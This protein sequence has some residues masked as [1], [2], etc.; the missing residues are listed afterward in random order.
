MNPQDPSSPHNVPEQPPDAPGARGYLAAWL[1][2]YPAQTVTAVR[3]RLH[4][5]RR[6]SAD[7]ELDAE[8]AALEALL[9]QAA[10]Q[11]RR[12]IRGDHPEA[13]PQRPLPDAMRAVVADVQRLYRIE[14]D[15]PQ[16]VDAQ[17][18]G[19]QADLILCCLREGLIN[20]AKH[21]GAT[22]CTSSLRIDEQGIGFELTQIGDGA[23]A[24]GHDDAATS[25]VE[26][27]GG[28][29]LRT[30]SDRA[31]ALGGRLKL[32]PAQAPGEQTRLVLELPRG[33]ARAD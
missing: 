5:L 21:A 12:A 26:R 1:H 30:L 19:E 25:A 22:H 27:L 17:A 24:P 29:G 20:A 7:P 18:S 31:A 10:S 8:L 16:R 23:E 13:E 4:Q 14:C 32:T 9:E 15:L 11:I 2:D 3:L 28:T 33:S 6:R